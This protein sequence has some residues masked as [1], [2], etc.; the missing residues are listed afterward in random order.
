MAPRIIK[1]VY[2]TEYP[3]AKNALQIMS[4]A[5]YA[6]EA[7]KTWTGINEVLFRRKKNSRL[8]LTDQRFFT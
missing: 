4:L 6:S 1:S 2:I 8:L 7:E 3:R 5:A